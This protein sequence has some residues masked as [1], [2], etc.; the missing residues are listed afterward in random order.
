M[1]RLFIVEFVMIQGA[2][3]GPLITTV[4]I[5]LKNLYIEYVLDEP[6]EEK[7]E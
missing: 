6:K 3:L 2:I 7:Q 1:I 5:A 4:L